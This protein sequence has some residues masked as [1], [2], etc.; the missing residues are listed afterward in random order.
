[1]FGGK[2]KLSSFRFVREAIAM[3]NILRNKRTQIFLAVLIIFTFHLQIFT[4]SA[5]ARGSGG[6]EMGKFDTGKFAVSVGVGLAL[7]AVGNAMSSGMSGA[8][9]ST[10]GTAG[11]AFADGFGSSIGTWGNVGTWANNYSSMFALSQVGA[12]VNTMGQQQDWGNSTTVMASS[13]VQGMTGGFLNPSSVLGAGAVSNTTIKAMT[14]GA[15]SGVTEG[16]ILANNIDSDG[17][18]NPWVSAGAGLV[19]SFVG[20][21]ASSGM[22]KVIPNDSGKGFHKAGSFGEVVT[23]GGVR[24]FS[25]IPSELIGVGVSNITKDMDKQDAFMVRQAFGGVYPVVGVVYQNKFRDPVFK[26]LGLDNYVGHN[27]VAGTELRKL[28]RQI[29]VIQTPIMK[30]NVVDT[31]I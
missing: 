20:G 28:D 27:G 31:N 7:M 9:S 19:G 26:K 25:S 4:Q 14:V 21:V 16:V 17:R 5:F 22:A 8:Y 10:A 30:G 23:H 15:I 3:K 11:S 2:G 6:G 13:V 12:A 18:I 1:M 24:T 29:K